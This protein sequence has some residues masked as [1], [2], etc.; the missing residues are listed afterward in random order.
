MTTAT[1][2]VA[3]LFADITNSMGLFLRAG[4]LVAR[5][6]ENEWLSQVRRLLPPFG[7]RF[8]KAVGD[9][10]MCV[11]PSADDGVLAA[12]EIQT[13]VR[14]QS[15]CDYRLRL[16]IGV[17]CGPVVEEDGDIFGDTVNVASYL[18]AA[19]VSE[20]ILIAD[21]TYSRLSAALRAYSRP[22][23]RTRL[24]AHPEETVLYQ[25][26]WKTDD[27]DVTRNFFAEGA[28]NKFIPA[29]TG[30]LLLKCGEMTIHMNHRKNIVVIG[31]DST[32]DLVINDSLVSRR[33]AQIT[34][35][36]GD[37]YLVDE[38]VN[39]TFVTL[40]DGEEIEIVRSD[41]L[42]EGSGRISP[43]RSCKDNPGGVIE[44]VRDRRS[45][46]RP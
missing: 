15:F 5:N 12:T 2:D 37:F 27:L 46:Y 35:L 16:H 13:L 40:E 8:V 34:L 17:H 32:C 18:C 36:H 11:F 41:F 4:D 26:L 33:H 22:I 20:Q 42:L 28:G 14:N 9:E 31:R 30:G 23:F 10:A 39:G 19:A 45:L 21:A 1:T 24:K 6:V 44:F 3:V 38:S 25:V 29:E 7:G 43:G